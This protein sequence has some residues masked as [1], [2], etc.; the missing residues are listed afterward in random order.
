MKHI[1]FLM[2]R[3]LP[4]PSANSICCENIIRILLIKGYKVTCLTYYDGGEYELNPA[5]NYRIIKVNRG[6]MYRIEITQNCNRFLKLIVKIFN[7]IKVILSLYRWPW[8]DPLYT[9]RLYQS[10]EK[11][12]ESDPFSVVV[13]VHM[14]ISSLIVG[15]RLKRRHPDIQYIPY[16][17]DSLSGGR[18]LSFFSYK[19]N[20]KHKLKWESKLSEKSDSIVCLQASYRHHQKYSANTAFFKKI[21]F[22]DIPLF[23]QVPYVNAEVPECF[24]KDKINILFAGTLNYPMRDVKNIISVAEETRHSDFRLIFIG[25]SNCY[26]I[27]NSSRVDI[28]YIPHVAHSQLNSYFKNADILLNLGVKCE[29]AIS[30]KI[31]E[32]IA[33]HK[34]IISTYSIDNESCI[35]YLEK[36]PRALLLDERMDLKTQSLKFYQFVTLCKSKQMPIVDDSYYYLNTPEAFVREVIEREE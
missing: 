26:S 17:L 2:G 34:P 13:A 27:L 32:Y 15:D 23:C 4:V 33:Y 7:R 31:F 24:C 12:Y 28:V 35:P 19:W 18:P 11:L 1:L 5:P 20:L 10:A 29:S 14:P 22:M 30:G 36:Y 16:Y 9:K 6:K 21:I 3:H 25:S 8:Q